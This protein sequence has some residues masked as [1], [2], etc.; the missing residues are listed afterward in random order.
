[1]GKAWVPKR[2]RH[3]AS[4]PDPTVRQEPAPVSSRRLAARPSTDLRLAATPEAA[5][6]GWAESSRTGSL[7]GDAC[8]H[9]PMAV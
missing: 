6:A 7:G 9:K 4:T 1:M 2:A 3:P 8:R 5:L